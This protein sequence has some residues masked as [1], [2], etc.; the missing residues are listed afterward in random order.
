VSE[1]ES[2][3][4]VLGAHLHLEQQVAISARHAIGCRASLSAPKK[5]HADES[6]DQLDEAASI[7]ASSRTMVADVNRIRRRRFSGPATIAWSEQSPYFTSC[8]S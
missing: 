5:Y 7:S 3:F 8:G 4:P 2:H 6:A 1:L